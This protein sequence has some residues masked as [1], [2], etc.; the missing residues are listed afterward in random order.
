MEKKKILENLAVAIVEG[1][2]NKA[3]EIAKE[4]LSNRIDP[5]EAIEQGLSKGMTTVGERFE[6]GEAYLPELLMAADTFNAGM[7]IL[8]PEMEVQ[9][10]QIA[11]AGTVLIGTVKGDVHSIGKNIVATVLEIHGFEVRDLGVDNPSLNIIQEAEK[12]KADVIALS[13]LMTT[14]MPAQKEVIETLKEMHLR[15]KYFVIVGGGPVNQEWADKIGADGY[16]KSAV[17]AV[18]IVKKLLAKKR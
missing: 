1:D 12:V 10:K 18:E 6:K 2:K 8:K 7:E 3:K 11:K 14:T 13:S 16:G 17:Q 5:L 9:K 4:A 15:D